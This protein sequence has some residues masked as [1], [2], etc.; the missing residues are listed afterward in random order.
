MTAPQSESILIVDFGSQVT[1]LIARR[2]REAGV[3]CEIHP[4]NNFDAAQIQAFDPKG[5]I[6]SGGPASTHAEGSPRA[7]QE[8]YE[9][10]LTPFVGHFVG[11]PGMNFVA[12]HRFGY[13]QATI[14][15]RPE[16]AT[17][18]EFG[19][20]N[21]QLEGP[22]GERCFLGTKDRVSQGLTYV[23]TEYGELAVE[24][25]LRQGQM[26]GVA[27]SRFVRYENEKLVEVVNVPAT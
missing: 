1:Q 9:A 2:V 13:P 14:G 11:S 27:V 24:G 17:L 22:V 15:F 6:L 7:P 26:L 19:A 5:V 4:F 25:P 10:P 16:W 3:Y 18:T 20:K 23:A 12:G 21:A 8:I